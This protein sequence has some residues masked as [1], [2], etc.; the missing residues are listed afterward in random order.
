MKNKKYIYMVGLFYLLLDQVI[1]FIV[2]KNMALMEEIS[3]IPKFFSIYYLKNNGA[4]FSIMGNKTIF[5]IVVAIICLIVLKY[6]IKSLKHVNL[7]S[8]I[9]LG[10]MMGGIVGNLF[11][12]VFYQAVVDYLAFTFGKYNFPVFNLADIGITIGAVLL[13]ISLIKEELAI[14]KNSLQN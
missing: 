13:L 12:R 3:I 8:I 10:M 9:S 11:D 7:L 1:K 4:A 5:L 14:K 6:Y 2:T